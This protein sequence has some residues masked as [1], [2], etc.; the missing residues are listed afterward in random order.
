MIFL[1]HK[2]IRGNT[3]R[4][5][6]PV[7]FHGQG[8]IIFLYTS[9]F[10]IFFFF[11]FFYFFFFF[12]FNFFFIFYFFFFFFIYFFFFFLKD[13]T[14]LHGQGP[15]KFLYTHKLVVRGFPR[16][17][18]RSCVHQLMVSDFWAPIFSCAI[19]EIWRRQFFQF[20][21]RA[22]RYLVCWP[23]CCSLLIEVCDLQLTGISLGLQN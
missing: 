5:G 21:S 8:S 22:L 20:G 9:G 14:R 10:F 3:L 7:H 11:Y 19:A 15:M 1:L 13:L 12:F 2:F 23:S 18:R 16:N 4:R 17:P 6:S